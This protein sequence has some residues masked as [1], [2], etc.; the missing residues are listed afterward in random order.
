MNKI[1]K[2]P[3]DLGND[4]ESLGVPVLGRISDASKHKLWQTRLLRILNKNITGSLHAVFTHFMDLPQYRPGRDYSIVLRGP[5]WNPADIFFLPCPLDKHG[6]PDF[7]RINLKVSEEAREFRAMLLEIREDLPI[8]SCAWPYPETP[9]GYGFCLT[10]REGPKSIVTLIENYSIAQGAQT[11]DD[12]NPYPHL[13]PHDTIED[14]ADV[15]R[16]EAAIDK[17]PCG[18][19]P[20]NLRTLPNGSYLSL[21]QAY[22]SSILAQDQ[23]PSLGAINIAHLKAL[24]ADYLGENTVPLEI[25]A[26]RLQ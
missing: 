23:R 16:L 2:Q 1:F 10:V 3:Q 5:D 8:T 17:K 9:D 13:D 18:F 11:W 22:V 15:L 20:E 12:I 26:L 4:L 7:R 25:L 21:K 19:L 6:N 24:V 14:V